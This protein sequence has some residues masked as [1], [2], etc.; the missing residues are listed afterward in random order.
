MLRQEILEDFASEGIEVMLDTRMHEVKGLSGQNVR[1]RPV[2]RTCGL[3]AIV[4]AAPQFTHVA[5][6]DFRVVRDNLNEGSRTTRDRLT[7][8]FLHVHNRSL[9]SQPMDLVLDSSR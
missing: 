8:A 7:N 4:Q 1:C 5:Y 6:D 2:R 3:W 9:G